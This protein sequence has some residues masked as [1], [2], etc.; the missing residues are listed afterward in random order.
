MAKLLV[1]I[2]F[3]NQTKEELER[4]LEAHKEDWFPLPDKQKISV[5]HVDLEVDPLDDSFYTF[6][7][8]GVEES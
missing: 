1:A 2:E 7:F 8:R 3:P 4:S 5:D 6:Q